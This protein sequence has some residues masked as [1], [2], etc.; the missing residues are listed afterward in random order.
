MART[1]D[2]SSLS[3][4]R[5]RCRPSVAIPSPPAGMIPTPKPAMVPACSSSSGVPTRMASAPHC[6]AS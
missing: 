5:S 4:N 1:T 6:S 3:L 2:G